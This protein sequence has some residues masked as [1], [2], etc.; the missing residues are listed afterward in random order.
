MWGK[1]QLAGLNIAMA[2]TLIVAIIASVVSC[3]VKREKE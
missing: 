2:V 3:F 1:W